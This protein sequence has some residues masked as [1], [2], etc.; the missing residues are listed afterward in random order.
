MPDSLDI[1]GGGG[2]SF[3][4]DA[5]G[6]TVTGKVLS[7]E[8]QQQTDMN[9]GELAFW[10]SGQPKMMYVVTLATDDR[11]DQWDD[12]RRTI[13]LRGS[14]KPESR[15]IL[16]AVVS[17][18]QAATGGTNL[19]VGGLLTVTYSGDG[20]STRRGFNP[21]KQ[22]TATYQPPSVDLGGQQ[23]AQQPAQPAQA[24]PAAQQP[25]AAPQPAPQPA[26]A[27]QPAQPDPAALAAALANLTPQQKA[28]LG[29]G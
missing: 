25:P 1:G 16:A 27:A 8:E 10:E 5:P 17:A 2:N 21:P 11:N 18:V 15:S 9:T 7:L 19:Q 12:G 20:E 24:T 6:D 29:L 26:A 23:P 28:A 4:F 13:Y 3:R 14:R 22:Y